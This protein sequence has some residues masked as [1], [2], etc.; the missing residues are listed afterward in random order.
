MANGR[1]LMDLE[2]LSQQ[3]IIISKVSKQLFHCNFICVK[4]QKFVITESTLIL[5]RS[6][7]PE[8]EPYRLPKA[9]TCKFL[10]CKFKVAIKWFYLFNYF[11][12]ISFLHFSAVYCKNIFVVIFP[13]A[14]ILKVSISNFIWS[15]Q[16][17]PHC[18]W[19]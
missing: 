13:S 18:G 6:P 15:F 8:R 2:E 5:A 3:S 11:M 19:V 9:Q 16:A 17:I 14:L 7:I 10:C 4:F 1:W 12:V